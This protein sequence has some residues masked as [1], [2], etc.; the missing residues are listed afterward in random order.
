MDDYPSTQGKIS[1]EGA[2]F[3]DKDGRLRFVGRP[4]GRYRSH[5]PIDKAFFGIQH[6]IML[7]FGT[8]ATAV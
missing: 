5:K 2:Y 1:I 3:R 7:F 4:G 8:T 6:V